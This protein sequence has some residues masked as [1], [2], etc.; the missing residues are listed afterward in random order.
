MPNVQITTQVSTDE[1][2]HSVS[3]LPAQE[4]DQ[5]VSRVLALRAKLKAPSL[6]N[7][8]TELLHQ[9]NGAFD[10]TQQQRWES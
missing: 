10:A 5:F 1:L 4:L 6:S 7:Q 2:L 3:G 8:E 9:I